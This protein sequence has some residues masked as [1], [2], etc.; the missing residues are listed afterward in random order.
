MAITRAHSDVN[1]QF[2]VRAEYGEPLKDLVH[3]KRDANNRGRFLF[4]H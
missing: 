3:I 1:E 4:L 2:A